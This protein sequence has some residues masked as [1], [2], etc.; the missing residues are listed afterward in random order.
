METEKLK[1]ELGSDRGYEIIIA[2]QNLKEFGAHLRSLQFGNSLLII[3]TPVINNLYGEQLRHSLKEAGFASQD[4]LLVEVPDGEQSKSVGQW[5]ELVEKLYQFDRE[6]KRQVLLI[7]FGGGVVGDLGGY[8]A[9]SYRRGID[10][11][12]LPTTLLSNVDSAVGGKV[13]VDFKDAKNLI[14]AFYQPRLVWV[15]LALLKSLDERQIKSGLAEVIKYGVICD[16]ELFNFVEQHY[17]D[18]LGLELWALK[19]IVVTS[20]AIKAKMVEA[21]ERD[22]CGVRI[23]LNLGHTVGHAVEAA[24]GYTG[25]THGEAVALGM[26]CAAAIAKELGMLSQ[27]E[28]VRLEKLLLKVGLPVRIKGVTLAQIMGSLLHDKKFIRGQNRFVLPTK[29]GEVQI[30]EG[31]SDELIRQVIAARLH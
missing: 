29:I 21:D 12:Q 24:A 23:M 26:V 15:D 5:L 6:L 10:Y 8:V 13:G 11:V 25:Y 1:V 20:Y 18:I 27:A 31:V 4:I 22:K 19:R 16:A 30:R 7:N 28:L 17:K 14:G 9:A 2:S 3:T